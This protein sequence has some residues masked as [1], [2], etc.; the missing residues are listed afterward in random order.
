MQSIIFQDTSFDLRDT[1]DNKVKK[2]LGGR[3]MTASARFIQ[4]L[5]PSSKVLRANR[6]RKFDT[7]KCVYDCS[8]R[9]MNVANLLLSQLIDAIENQNPPLYDISKQQWTGCPDLTK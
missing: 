7:W 2:D 3:K 5:F 4:R 9:P 1:Y 6:A 8:N